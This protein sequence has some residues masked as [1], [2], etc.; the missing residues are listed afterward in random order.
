MLAVIEALLGAPHEDLNDIHSNLLRE[1][2]ITMLMVTIF[3][4]PEKALEHNIAAYTNSVLRGP[5]EADA[6]PLLRENVLRVRLSR[7]ARLIGHQLG[8]SCAILQIQLESRFVTH[9][10]QRKLFSTPKIRRVEPNP[11]GHRNSER[12]IRLISQAVVKQIRCQVREVDQLHATIILRLEL[13]DGPVYVVA[14]QGNAVH[15]SL[16]DGDGIKGRRDSIA[17]KCA[18]RQRVFPAVI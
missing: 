3:N 12:A 5:R 13:H 18:G 7:P 8:V 17:A 9:I 1:D 16:I 6:R 15:I 4:D 10:E 14:N 11:R 2:S